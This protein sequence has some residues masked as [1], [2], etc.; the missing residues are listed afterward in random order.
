MNDLLRLS[1]CSLARLIRDREVTSAETVSAHLRRIRETNPR[2]NAVVGL[3]TESAREQAMTADEAVGRGDVLPPLHGVPVTI[4]DTI[5]T[6][7]VVTTSGLTGRRNHV[8]TDDATVVSRLKK[9]GAIIIGKTNTPELA[10]C[11]DTDN[12]VYG[13][14]HNPHDLSRTPG[15]SS[16]GEAAIIAAGGSP[17]GLGSDSGGSVRIP[18]HFCG[19]VSLKPTL[20]R[21]PLTGHFPLNSGL[22][23]LLWQIGPMARHVE[24]LALALA[25]ISGPDGHDPVTT[26]VVLGDH[27]DI[28]P[29]SL[30]IACYCEED[31]PHTPETLAALQHAAKAL[32]SAGAQIVECSP[33]D[34][35]RIV[36]WESALCYGDGAQWVRDI[37][38]ST[39]TTS[40]HP[41]LSKILDEAKSLKMTTDSF[42]SLME[43]I[44]GFKRRMLRFMRSYDVLLSPA[45]YSPAPPHEHMTTIDQ[46]LWSYAMTHNLTGWPAAIVPAGV[47]NEGLPIGVQLAAKP[48]REDIV[49]RAASIVESSIT[50]WKPAML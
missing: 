7:G 11:D 28:N 46:R 47:S 44:D 31:R 2:I 3:L 25:V 39:G 29:S 1:A 43:D 14:T 27:L 48:W 41:L 10:L 50:D 9:A 45:A 24:D 23:S 32:E 13:L 6:A 30:R 42:F 36:E 4:K 35:S 34:T 21:V 38:D 26:P 8:P 49:L 12:L 22:Q 15:S 20:G 17:L 18:A 40:I 33:P 5:D 16:G 37:L 19:I